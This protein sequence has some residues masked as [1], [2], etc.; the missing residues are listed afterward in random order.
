[1]IEQA[2]GIIA[3]RHALDMNQAFTAL[4]RHARRTGQPLSIVAAAVI[5]GT[6]TIT[7]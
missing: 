1:M 2:K 4:R 7:A 3:E 5:D 6:L